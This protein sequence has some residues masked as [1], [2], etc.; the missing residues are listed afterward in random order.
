MFKKVSFKQKMLFSIM[1]AVII[2]MLILSYAAFYSFRKNIEAELIGSRTETTKKLS[3]NINTWLQGKLLEVRMETNTSAAKSITTDLT[4]IDKFNASRIKFLNENY[5]GEYDNAASAL[6][7]NDG[8]SRA[9]YAN[10]NSVIGDVS[11]KAW[12]KALMSGVPYHISNPV[13]SKGTGKTITVIGVPIKDDSNKSIGLMM[14]AVNLS[15]IENKVKE[16]KYG[17]NGYAMLIGADG[18]L[19]VYPDKNLVMKKKITDINDKNMK[20]LGK[21]MLSENSGLYRFSDGKDNLMVFYNKVPLSNWS[22]ASV[23]YEN[24]LFAQVKQMIINQIIITL[25]LVA[26][27]GAI[28]MYV[29]K[30]IT[31]PLKELSSFSSEIAEGNLNG[32]LSM[33]Q[34][35]EVGM[36]AG[37]LNSTVTKLKEIIKSISDSA[38]EVSILSK[39]LNV[40]T[41]ESKK[42]IE[43]TANTMEQIAGGAVKQAENADSLLS[44]TKDLVEDIN[45]VLS[46]S[47]YM[48]DVVEESKKT[49]SSGIS[50]V[51]EAVRSMELLAETNN[52]N[53]KE[54]KN[55]LKQSKEV[56]QIVDVITGIAEQTNL[57]ALNAAIEAARAGDQGKGFAVVADEVGSL[58]EKSGEAAKQIEDIINKIQNQIETIAKSMDKSNHEVNNGV[59]LASEAGASFSEIEKSFSDITSIVLEVSEAANSMSNKANSTE[60]TI[61][62]FASITEENSAA[63]E[64]VSASAEEQSAGMH[65]IGETARRLD[66]LVVKLKNSIDW[67][68]I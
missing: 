29:A 22:V 38:G 10:G 64:E 45:M 51:K 6:F 7:N 36:V 35:D 43:E 27:I 49:S 37:S 5:P 46:K 25:I 30:R 31:S 63:T 8:K 34:Q 62:N 18:T 42:A 19:V 12:Y 48:K 56:G 26:I 40:T 41:N 60:D 66:D 55:L 67:F 11:E 21:K 47:L 57:L 44:V 65:Q 33:K 13:V 24:E 2:G 53:V 1:P 17:K 16:F 3:D 54:T 20:A 4:G 50:G 28:I 39:N 52:Y 15:S 68:K 14:S 58:A 23:V 61:T 59:K 32:K 9:Q